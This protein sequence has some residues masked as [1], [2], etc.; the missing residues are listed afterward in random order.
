MLAVIDLDMIWPCGNNAF[1]RAPGKGDP[2]HH[3]SFG[4]HHVLFNRV[5]HTS[6]AKLVTLM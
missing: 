5:S 4:M 2:N 6:T 1:L 3:A